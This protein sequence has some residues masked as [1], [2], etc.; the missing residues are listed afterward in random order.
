MK[1]INVRLLKLKRSSCTP[2]SSPSANCLD[3]S[4]ESKDRSRC[5][6]G[7][8]PAGSD[9]VNAEKT[10]DSTASSYGCRVLSSIKDYF[11]DCFAVVTNHLKLGP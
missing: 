9:F 2:S 4:L 5:G 6:G 8:K 7:V 11:S 1:E 3:S 10:T